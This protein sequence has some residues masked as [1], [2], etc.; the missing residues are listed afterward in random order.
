M[1]DGR[2]DDIAPIP[3]KLGRNTVQTCSFIVLTVL[4]NFYTLLSVTV[5]T[6]NFK[7]PSFG[8]KKDFTCILSKS[9]LG[10]FN[11]FTRSSATLQKKSQNLFATD[12]FI[13]RGDIPSGYPLWHGIFVLLYRTN[14]NLVKY[15]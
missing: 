14:P 8:I 4:I 11:F 9:P 15:Q 6:K 2:S 7:E 5:E 13:P 1:G 3:Y 12:F 10:G